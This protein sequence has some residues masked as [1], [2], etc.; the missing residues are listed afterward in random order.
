MTA[1]AKRADR[2]ITSV[3]HDM[4]ADRWRWNVLTIPDV[5]NNG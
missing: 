1:A 5:M 4:P 3:T 2:V